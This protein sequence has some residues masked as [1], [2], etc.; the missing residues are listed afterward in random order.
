MSIASNKQTWPA[1]TARPEGNASS[2]VKRILRQGR[3]EAVNML[4]NGEQLLVSMVIPVMV[5]IGVHTMGLLDTPEYSTIEIVTPGVLAIAVLSSAFTSQGIQTAFDRRYGVL[6]YL[7]TTPLGSAGLVLGKAIAV[8]VTLIV[9]VI[10]IMTVAVFLGYPLGLQGILPSLVF[11]LLGAI[12]FTSL[13]LLIAGTLRPEATLAITNLL[14][15]V[16]GAAGGTVFPLS[17]DGFMT[18]ILQFL[19]SAALGD[20]LREALLNG[21]FATGPFIILLLWAAVITALTTKFYSWK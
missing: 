18:P 3:Y 1:V 2:V 19:P 12:A 16:L 11:L 6:R 7:A 17:E 10:V 20:G 15:V 8:L 5:I 13:G 9:Q 14:W 4:K 21:G